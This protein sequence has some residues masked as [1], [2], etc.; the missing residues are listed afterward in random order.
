MRTKTLLLAAALSAAG[1]ISSVAQSNVYSINVVG[2]VNR[3]CTGNG[4]FTLL[5]NPLD[6]GTNTLN[7]VLAAA[8]PANSKVLKWNG[9]GFTTY[10][11]TA[12]GWLPP[13]AGTVTVNPGEGFFV[14]TPNPSAA[15]PITFVGNVLQGSLTNNYPLLFNLSG[16]L[17]PDSGTLTSLGMTPPAND[18]ILLWNGVGYTTY[19]K[20]ASGWLP[21]AGPSINVADGFFVNTPAGTFSWVR[22]VTVN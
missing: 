17:F 10:Q 4:A 15:V 12:S 5:A 1:I 21:P 20:T 11:R 18:K 19:T 2:Y 6:S 8:L 9:T 14:Q 7:G 13:S 16:N 22:N 3:D